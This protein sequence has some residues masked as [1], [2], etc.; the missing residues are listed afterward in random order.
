MGVPASGRSLIQVLHPSSF[1]TLSD[2]KITGVVIPLYKNNF[3]LYDPYAHFC[4]DALPNLAALKRLEFG[5]HIYGHRNLYP[6]DFAIGQWSRL[7]NLLATPGCLPNLRGLIIHT[8]IRVIVPEMRTGASANDQSTEQM[9]DEHTK[10]INR[11][12]VAAEKLSEDLYRLVYE[13]QYR[14]LVAS[15]TSLGLSFVAEV[16]MAR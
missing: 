4:D 5:I 7:P 3:P 1:S 11:R 14:P 6:D 13:P 9:R 2:L 12:N 10:E 16:V 8:Y 15:R